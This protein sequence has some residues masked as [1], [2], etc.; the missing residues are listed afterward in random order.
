[1]TTRRSSLNA[2]EVHVL[3]ALA[4]G[5]LYGYA[6][7][8]A[9]E[10]ESGGSLAP[11]AGSLYRVLARMMTWGLVEE[12]DGVG[13]DEPHPGLERRYYALTPEGREALRGE[14]DRM[15]TAAALAERRLRVADSGR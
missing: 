5:P 12:A 11:R 7:K 3:L 2:L 15:R 6:V 9:V 14:A 10:R 4:E 1:M 13:G 8:E